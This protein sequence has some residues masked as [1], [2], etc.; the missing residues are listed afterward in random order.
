L[1][2]VLQ[3]WQEAEAEPNRTDNIESLIGLV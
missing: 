2:A 1:E 3:L